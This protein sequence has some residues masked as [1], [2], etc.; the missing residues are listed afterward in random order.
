[1]KSAKAVHKSYKKLI[2]KLSFDRELVPNQNHGETVIPIG[3][4]D[5]FVQLP[6]LANTY[7]YNLINT[8]QMTG[9]ITLK[10]SRGAS[11]KGLILNNVGGTL[12]IEPI[13]QGA[14]SFEMGSDVKDGCFVQT[15]SNG[16]N[17]FI[18]SVATHGSLGIGNG[19]GNSAPPQ[20]STGTVTQIP[21]A[22][23]VTITSETTFPA[24]SLEARHQLTI[25]GR[26]EPGTTIQVSEDNG[27]INTITN[28]P[29]DSNGDWGPLTIPELL[30]SGTYSFD[31]ID[32]SSN[33]GTAVENELFSDNTGALIFTTP[34][35]FTVERGTSFD[36]EAG[37][38][39]TDPSGN[40]IASFNT[41]DSA[42]NIAL[43][44][45]ATF[46]IVYSFTYNATPYTRT[47]SG[48]VEDTIAPAKPTI[49]SA[50]FDSVN[51]NDFTATGA[52]EDGSTVEIF[53]DGVSQGT[54]TSIGGTW[55]FNQTFHFLQTFNITVQATDAAGNPSDES[56]PT[57]VQ[58]NPPTLTRPTLSIDNATAATWTNQD[59]PIQISGTTDAGSA[60]VIK[61]GS[62]VVTPVSGPTYSGD[63]WDAEINVADE[64]NSSLTVEAS[65]AN[66]NSPSPSIAK[67]LLVDRV[68]PVISLTGVNPQI[69]YLGNIGANNDQGAT[70]TDFSSAT[71]SSDWTTQVNAVEGAKTVTYTAT[72]LAGNTATDT[73]TV[74]VSTEV[75]VPEILTVTT[76]VSTATISGDVSGTYADNLVVKIYVTDNNGLEEV[77]QE[78]GV[79]V[80]F[81]VSSGGFSAVLTLSPDTY[82]FQA[83]TVNSESEESSQSAPTTTIVVTGVPN[84]APT[85]R[86]VAG[87]NANGL[88]HSTA[89]VLHGTA[90]YDIDEV[91]FIL[92]NPSNSPSDGTDFI[93]IP[94]S[95][96][97][98]RPSSGDLTI[99]LWFN[100]DRLPDNE[101]GGGR[102][103]GLIS[104]TDAGNTNDGGWII[105]LT[106]ESGF[107][108]GGIQAT[109]FPTPHNR[110]LPSGGVT[111][112]SWHHVALVIRNSGD[113]TIYYDGQEI[114]TYTYGSNSQAGALSENYPLIIGGFSFN[115]AG[116]SIDQHFDGKIKGVA[117]DQVEISAAE[118][119]NN[120]N[121]PP[122]EVNNAAALTTSS[123]SA[124]SF[125]GFGED[126]EDGALVPTTT[127]NPDPFDITTENTYTIE[128]SV[129]DSAS[130]E[131]THS[132][133]IQVIEPQYSFLEDIPS[134][135]AR[136]PSK[137]NLGIYNDNNHAGN[138][139]MQVLL[140]DDGVL[141]YDPS[142]N[143]TVNDEF[144][145]S[146]WMNLD[147][148]Q[149]AGNLGLA[150]INVGQ[151]NGVVRRFAFDLGGGSALTNPHFTSNTRNPMTTNNLSTG[152]S[153]AEVWTHVAI[154]IKN[155]SSNIVGSIYL[156]G[157]RLSNSFSYPL[158]TKVFPPSSHQTFIFGSGF[159]SKSVKGQ[160]DSMQISDGVALTDPQVLAIYDQSDR[161]MTIA[162]AAAIQ[163]TASAFIEDNS[164]ALTV[165]PNADLFDDS[166]NTIFR[167][168][169]P[170]AATAGYAQGNW[171]DYVTY[172]GGSFSYNS[173]T[174]SLWFNPKEHFTSSTETIMRLFSSREAS[175]TDGVQ[176]LL[177]RSSSNFYTIQ[178]SYY[179]NGSWRTKNLNGNSG[180]SA[181]SFAINSWRHIVAVFDGSD[182]LVFLDGSEARS[183]PGELTESL[184][185]S[186]NDSD[187]TFT[188]GASNNGTNTVNKNVYIDSVEIVQNV[189][190]T[191]HQVNAMS[192][193]STRQTTIAEAASLPPV[194]PY[195][196][197]DATK[198][199]NAVYS[200]CTLSLGGSG[201]YATVSDNFR[202]EDQLSISLWFKTSNSNGRIISSHIAGVGSNGFF[203]GLSGGRLQYRTPNQGSGTTNGPPSLNDGNWHHVVVTW[204][205][206]YP[207]RKLYV[208]N[209]LIHEQNAGNGAINGYVSNEDLYIGAIKNKNTG[210]IYDFFDGEIARVEVLNEVLDSTAVTTRYNNSNGAC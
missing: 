45:N 28:I 83:T 190:L 151:V 100:A 76:G 169:P 206:G 143:E 146:W 46:D 161:Q 129:T 88:E 171:S 144:T 95:S 110:T 121:N 27:A 147:A 210:V 186:P 84:N 80:E 150:G 58:Y 44:H 54:V 33:P 16:N 64:S 148:S 49:A 35:S 43:A 142:T 82:I 2:S 179:Y 184:I 96:G 204:T 81:P 137:F 99:Q 132:F 22:V 62:Q 11:L 130:E 90:A 105:A 196:E 136:A 189:V 86:V 15:L 3:S 37:A 50:T 97:F 180:E 65:K 177:K 14:T 53:F 187:A 31:F 178:L 133:T 39:A 101:G 182:I 176:L 93:E 159:Q 174:I 153:M 17:W 109:I 135:I 192:T 1:M 24:P 77:Y 202:Y 140:K 91:A 72:D 102:N 89:A 12:N 163:N 40:Q 191:E 92:D 117:I 138:G 70:A 61:D 119:L 42:Y 78:S 195:I 48:V 188:L 197:I 30:E 127:S 6:S 74:N 120:Y 71:V 107:A 185:G 66:F 126:A 51:I 32:E 114:S 125:I 94:Y 128:H 13:P 21:A 208:D 18:W 203:I 154:V 116:T 9:A 172:N 41:D 103:F 123:N 157:A 85:L 175:G 19:G 160:F 20:V 111:I 194:P 4:N 59:N 60:I 108:T 34:S 79:D 67:T 145:I 134:V 167:N 87:N 115:P 156:N 8:S 165:T 36:F 47:I 63:D 122:I 68:D 198:H 5:L 69:V 52:A 149:V 155:D 26:A 112:G 170:L 75:I 207:N 118:I 139:G 168:F 98:N 141:E 162:E 205:F 124:F 55:T 10:T 201:D 152:V 199:G 25:Q 158:G 38:Y 29:V 57:A 73:R 173:M 7:T 23:Q 56:I 104:R 131:T 164:G 113:A 200:N 181:S 183:L 106:T 209:S 193:D 166:G